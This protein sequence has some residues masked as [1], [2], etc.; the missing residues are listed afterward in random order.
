LKPHPFV[1]DIW[2][3]TGEWTLSTL[4]TLQ[5]MNQA[6]FLYGHDHNLKALFIGQALIYARQLA[7]QREKLI[8]Q[9]RPS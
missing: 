5:I 2:H 6:E 4:P 3:S 1:H 7:E 8:N 9:G